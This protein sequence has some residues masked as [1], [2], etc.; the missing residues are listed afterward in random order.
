[1]QTN[2]NEAKASVTPAT[3]AGHHPG[4]LRFKATELAQTP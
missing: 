1:M 2:M 4:W 3:F